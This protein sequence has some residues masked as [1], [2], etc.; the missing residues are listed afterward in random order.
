MNRKGLAVSVDLAPG[1]D[2]RDDHDFVRRVHREDDSPTT[3]AGGASSGLASERLRML[4]VER[5]VC[6]KSEPITHAFL[7][8]TVEPSEISSRGTMEPNLVG[9]A[10]LEAQLPLQ[11]VKRDIV[12]T[13]D[14]GFCPLHLGALFVRKGVVLVGEQPPDIVEHFDRAVLIEG[15]HQLDNLFF[16]RGHDF[17]SHSRPTRIVHTTSARNEF[18]G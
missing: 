2:P 1:A 17:D 13:R 14:L 9:H 12:A 7:V 15:T 5:V 3:Y 8:P 4:S 18:H 16:R 6:E 11:F 10:E